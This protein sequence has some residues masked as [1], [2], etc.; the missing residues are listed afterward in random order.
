MDHDDITVEREDLPLRERLRIKT[1]LSVRQW[2]WGLTAVFTLP[3][4]V[5]V[6]VYLVYAVDETVF[7]VT[8]LVYSLVAMIAYFVL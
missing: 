5:F 6:Y 7:L 2:T 4:P 1:G 8:T 3:Y